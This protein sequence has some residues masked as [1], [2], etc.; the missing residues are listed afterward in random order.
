MDGRIR[1]EHFSADIR[2]WQPGAPG[3]TAYHGRLR[4]IVERVEIDAIREALT[5]HGGN[6]LRPAE[7]LGLTSNG[8][9]DKMARYGVM[10]MITTKLTR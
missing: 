10:L 8:L 7:D 2:S 5:E 9:K 4:D 1:P 6:I 3:Q